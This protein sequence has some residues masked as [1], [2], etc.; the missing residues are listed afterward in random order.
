[1][2]LLNDSIPAES[3]PGRMNMIAS[4]GRRYAYLYSLTGALNFNKGSTAVHEGYVVVYS[5]DGRSFKD[6]GC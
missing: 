3:I 4:Q 5:H 1:M 6:S 2:A